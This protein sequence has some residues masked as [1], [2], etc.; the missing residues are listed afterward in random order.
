[1]ADPNIG[2]T[3]AA[4]YEKVYPSKPTDNIFNSNA[5][6]YAL[7]EKGFKVSTA[8]GRLFECPVE[9][10]QN[11]NF[12]MV[13]DYEE[14]TTSRIDVFDAARY[15]RKIAGVFLI[16]HYPPGQSVDKDGKV[17]SPAKDAAGI[18]ALVDAY[19]PD[20]KN[21]T[22]QSPE[23]KVANLVGRMTPEEKAALIARL[24]GGN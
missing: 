19:R 13:G 1:M 20:V 5:L 21:V 6:F 4:S 15:D 17:T 14:L 9:Y 11:T 16:I 23:E 12:Q 8:G 2:Q 7:S 22:R 18:Q 24:T 10:A 3:I